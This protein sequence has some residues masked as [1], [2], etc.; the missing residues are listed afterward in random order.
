MKQSG[1]IGTVV[2]V[3]GSVVDVHFEDGLPHIDTLLRA[4]SQGEIAIEVL[5]QLNEHLVRGVALT[6]TQGLA[7]GMKVEDT[8]EPL[9]APVGRNI[10]SRMFDVFGRV[11]DRQ[12]GDHGNRMAPNR[13]YTPTLSAPFNAI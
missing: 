12:G 9:K 6:P 1:K 7:R 5:A 4:G 10:L 13:S 8:G 3:R 11:I 2:A